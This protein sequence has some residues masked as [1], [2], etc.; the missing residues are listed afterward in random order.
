MPVGACDNAKGPALKTVLDGS[1]DDGKGMEGN[2]LLSPAD[3]T[4]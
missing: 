3:C 4:G 1:T 2:S